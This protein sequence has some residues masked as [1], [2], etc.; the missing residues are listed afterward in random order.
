M[1]RQHIYLVIALV[2]VVIA[3]ISLQMV[4]ASSLLESGAPT[5]I[6]YQ[7]VVKESGTPY[8]GTG[9]FKFAVVNA[10]G[11][12]SYW[13]NDGTSSGGGEPTAGVSLTVSEGLFQV[14]LGDTRL[15]HMTA[16]SADVFSGI[17]RYLRVWFSSDGISYTALAPDQQ[18][19]SVP[20]AL[21][22]EEAHDADTL[23]GLHAAE[24]ETHYENVVVVAKSGGDYTTIQAAVD[25]IID[26]SDINP[27]L[28]WV[29]P[30]VYNETVTLK[31]HVHLQGA[32]QEV[33]IISSAVGDS[34][35]IPTQATLV[36]ASDSSVRDLTV[37]NMGSDDFNVA[38]LATGGIPNV[39]LA[40][41]TVRAQGVGTANYG[42][43]SYV[44]GTEISLYR[45]TAGAENGSDS[46][47]GLLNSGNAEAYLNGGVFTG[48]G[49]ANAY[50]ISN[51]AVLE[52]HQVT[53][54]GEYGSV[55]NS[56]LREISGGSAILRGGSFTGRGGDTAHGIHVTGVVSTL[57]AL[58]VTA[59]AEDASSE[60]YGTLNHSGA[61][62]SLVGGT[63]TARG[64]NYAYAVGNSDSD[65][66]LTA[67]NIIA[68]AETADF[69][70]V[71]LLNDYSGSVSL[72]GGTYIGKG[73]TNSYGIL[74]K[75]EDSILQA[76]NIYVLADAGG[77]GAGVSCR[78]NSTAVITQ[79]QIEGDTWSAQTMNGGSVQI[80]NSR[81][82]GYTSG[83]YG[84]ITCVLVTRGPII[85][86]DGYTCP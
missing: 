37:E 34:S 13:S 30:G 8:T 29:A 69:S 76:S 5:V 77:S 38:I 41:I 9:Y 54:L 61:E 40:D 23:D 31:S 22:A 79:S 36:L 18:F 10:A 14:L 4:S 24:L 58:Q 16:I 86:T 44:S 32:G 25:S 50:G 53:A 81:L 59:L 67:E 45:V 62:I 7:G 64:G 65:S 68:L 71:G 80:N 84:S 17:E 3:G 63:F 1:K 85:S 20:Y 55:W 15:A 47:Y 60:N 56:G 21:Q 51:T 43:F 72:Q 73:G 83:T 66:V 19:A 26:A 27:Y 46:N 39:V 48:R 28:V 74:N 78:D 70:T 75:N 2:L 57:E 12:I 35:P 52:A 33:A 11:D 6:G 49:G 42:I 82:K